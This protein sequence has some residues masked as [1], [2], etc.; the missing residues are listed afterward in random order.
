MIYARHYPKHMDMKKLDC[1]NETVKHETVKQQ[2]YT[3]R[4]TFDYV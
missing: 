1:R 4:D 2:L 3:R